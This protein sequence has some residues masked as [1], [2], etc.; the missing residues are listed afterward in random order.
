MIGC[1]GCKILGHLVASSGI[2]LALSGQLPFMAI[3]VDKLGG[4]SKQILLYSI[5]LNPTDLTDGSQGMIKKDLDK[6]T[7][8]SQNSHFK[9]T[10]RQ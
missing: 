3:C 6:M 5:S 2:K 7:F 8:I 10:P 4:H 1:F 9:T